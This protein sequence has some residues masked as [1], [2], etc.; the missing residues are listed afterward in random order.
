MTNSIDTQPEELPA[1][2]SAALAQARAR[3]STG[4][5][6]GRVLRTG[7]VLAAI[8]LVI[9]MVLAGA[10]GD[11]GGGRSSLDAAI[12]GSADH[13]SSFTDVVKGLGDAQPE[14]VIS[15]GLLVLV[16]TPIVRVLVAGID[17]FRRRDHLFAL[18]SLTVLVLLGA[19]FVFD[20]A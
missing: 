2:P 17:F 9:G 5:I 11:L 4:V 8:L 12:D 13:P 10:D 3:P 19:S 15:L 14:A 20:L 18:I 1:D 7:V 16:A 6:L